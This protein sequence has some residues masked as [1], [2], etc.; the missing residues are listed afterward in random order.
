MQSIT[1]PMKSSWRKIRK[2]V[3]KK[4]INVLLFTFWGWINIL[5]I[6]YKTGNSSERDIGKTVLPW[7]LIHVTRPYSWMLHSNKLTRNPRYKVDQ[8]ICLNWPI[9]NVN[10]FYCLDFEIFVRMP[11]T[12]RKLRRDRKY[13][14]EWC[15]L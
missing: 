4:K 14:I 12:P 6:K 15:I 2:I 3:K 7:N 5:N 11:I 1:N 8:L 13:F 9:L 10:T